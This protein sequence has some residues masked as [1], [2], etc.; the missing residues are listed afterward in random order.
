MDKNNQGSQQGSELRRRAE[1]Q[2]RAESAKS[3][4]PM[5]EYEINALLHELQVHQIELE[6]QNEELTRARREAEEIREQCLDL[7][8]FAPVGYFTFDDQGT[9]LSSNFTGAGLLATDRSS[10]VGRRFQLYLNTD[11]RVGFVECVKAIIRTGKKHIFEVELLKDGNRPVYLQIEGTAA[12]TTGEE[13]VCRAIAVD[14]T[15]RKKAEE[16]LRHR[17]YLLQRALIPT[18]PP[19]VQGYSIA[20]AY[21]PAFAGQEIGGDFFDVFKTEDGKLGIVIGDVSGKGLEA[22][23]LAA[24]ARSTVV[25]F[26]YD[27]SSPGGAL[28]HANAML[29]ARQLEFENFVTVF[30]VILDTTSG[31]ISYSSAGHPPPMIV[32]ANGDTEILYMLNNPPLGI[33]KGSWFEQASCNLMPGDRL[34]LYTDGISEA[35]SDSGL[36]GEEGIEQVLNAHAQATPDELVTYLLDA[37]KDWAHGKLRDDTALL[38]IGRDM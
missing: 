2:L 4:E 20:S 36:F 15:E 28:L 16:M 25:A 30:L 17:V 19:I 8:D 11:Y 37:A 27:L 23:A 38:I 34:V 5:S 18:T 24:I 31:D 1:D 32:H 9:I 13:R 29:A 33:I 21:I 35:R 22:A 14:V 12:E 6:M 7:Y 3:I 26:A 10:L